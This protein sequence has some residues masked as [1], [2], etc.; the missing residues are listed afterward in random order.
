MLI[1]FR[2]CTGHEDSIY[3]LSFTPDSHYL[4]STDISGTVLV[5]QTQSDH[6]KSLLRL[7]EAHDM[8]V[9]SCD[10]A[11]QRKLPSAGFVEV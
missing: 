10:M 3:S 4:V 6:A 5:W 11:E 1:S 8:G 7:E 2:I 9:H